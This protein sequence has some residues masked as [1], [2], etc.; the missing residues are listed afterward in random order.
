MAG[1]N[2]FFI[3]FLAAR[4]ISALQFT[5]KGGISCFCCT[6]QHILVSINLTQRIKLGFSCYKLTLELCSGF[7]SGPCLLSDV[8]CS[9]FT[10]EVT[11]FQLS[12]LQLSLHGVKALFYE[13]TFA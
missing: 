4:P 7:H 3:Q 10:G 5:L 9:V 1:V 13:F 2:I 11:Q 8:N 6:Y 12:A